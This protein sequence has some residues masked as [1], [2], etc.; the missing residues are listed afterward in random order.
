LFQ[1]GNCLRED[2]PPTAAKTYGQLL[3]EFPDSPWAGLASFQ[4]K[5]IDWYLKSEPRKLI[6]EVEHAASD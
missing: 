1:I 3:T 5:L 4:S 6:A 2:D